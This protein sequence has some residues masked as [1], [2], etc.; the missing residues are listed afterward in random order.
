MTRAL[1]VAALMLSA[2]LVDA[3]H[4]LPDDEAG[5]CRYGADHMMALAR[6]AVEDPRSRPE[7]SAKRRQLLDDWTSRIEAGEDPCAVY[8]D[9][10]KAATMF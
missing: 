2:L 5:R 3:Q 7:R 8:A 6:Q 1:A 4:G 9:I 10:Q